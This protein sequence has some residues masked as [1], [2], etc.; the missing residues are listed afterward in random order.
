MYYPSTRS[1]KIVMRASIAK[2][3]SVIL[4][5]AIS[6]CVTANQPPSTPPPPP[7]S[8]SFD[9]TYTGTIHLTSSSVS[10]N[11]LQAN[12]CDTPPQISL[13]V[14]NNRFT[15]HLTHPNVPQGM[16]LNLNAIVGPDGTISGSD[17]NGAAQMDGLVAASQMS[18]HINGSACNYAFTAQRI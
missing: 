11:P 5:I 6:G 3:S 16:S 17:V 18:G 1:G 12:W 13:S 14:Q 7:P 8:V 10:G 9:G 2:T 15:Y 4:S